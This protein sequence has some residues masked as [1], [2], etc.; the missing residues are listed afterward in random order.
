MQLLDVLEAKDESFS[1]HVMKV[2]EKYGILFSI[3]FVDTVIAGSLRVNSDNTV[4]ERSG[5]GVG[6]LQ[7][8]EL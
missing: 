7:K 1:K 5:K 4:G 3:C 2:W 8:Q 6:R